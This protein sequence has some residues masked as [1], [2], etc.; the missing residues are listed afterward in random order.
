MPAPLTAR[1]TSTVT[2]DGVGAG[3]RCLDAQ[4]KASHKRIRTAVVASS[5]S[6]TDI[7]GIGPVLA[8]MLIGY[9]GD[10]TRF[11]TR[12]HYAANDGTARRQLDHAI[13]MAAICQMHHPGS[14]GWLGVAI[15]LDGHQHSTASLREERHPSATLKSS[16]RPP[17]DRR[18]PTP[19][20]PPVHCRTQPSTP[21]VVPPRRR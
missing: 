13:H 9:T 8:A 10:I 5:T 18:E 1:V 21:P 14:A 3:A 7:S 15:D 16:V 20:S 2:H 17:K 11:R 4:L 6:L 12:D 19:T